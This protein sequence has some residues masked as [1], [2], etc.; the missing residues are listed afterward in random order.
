M[1]VCVWVCVCVYAYVHAGGLCVTQE[2]AA[3]DGHRKETWLAAAEMCGSVPKQT[4]NTQ[5]TSDMRQREQ[6]ELAADRNK[7]VDWLQDLKI[8]KAIANRLLPEPLQ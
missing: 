6:I 3:A 7:L 1:C 2:A 4:Q 8:E 5:N